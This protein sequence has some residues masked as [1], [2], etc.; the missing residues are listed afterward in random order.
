LTGWGNPRKTVVSR[1]RL[2]PSASLLQ[3]RNA[4][5]WRNDCSDCGLVDCY[6][7]FF[8][9]GHYR[10]GRTCC[11]HLQVRNDSQDVKEG[12]YSNLGEGAAASLKFSVYHSYWPDRAPPLSTSVY[13]SYWPDRAPTLSTFR[14][15]N[16]HAA[17]L[18]NQIDI[19]RSACSSTMKVISVS[20]FET[21]YTTIWCYILFKRVNIY[22]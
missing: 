12:S 4:I 15:P 2:K 18:C 5:A 20:S 17:C 6:T 8:I 9:C 22:H 7:A 3:I 13:H 14:G 11:L 21:T 1:P 16:F 19:V 10:F